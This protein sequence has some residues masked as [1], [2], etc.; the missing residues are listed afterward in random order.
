VGIEESRF[1]GTKM[2]ADLR[3]DIPVWNVTGTQRPGHCIA[4]IRDCDAE[5]ECSFRYYSGDVLVAPVN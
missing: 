4:I 1:E 2:L 5:H 3:V